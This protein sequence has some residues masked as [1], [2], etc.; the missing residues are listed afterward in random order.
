MYTSRYEEI[1]K[2]LRKEIYE[3][4]RDNRCY[5]TRIEMNPEVYNLFRA[6]VD[7]WGETQS[8]PTDDGIRF[9]FR[10]IEVV[11]IYREANFD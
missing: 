10:G 6:S 11:G 3:Y 9:T 2:K 7:M 5:P 8:E 1:C 4:E